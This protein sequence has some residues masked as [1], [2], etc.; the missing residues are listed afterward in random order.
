MTTAQE[1]VLDSPRALSCH[2]PVGL[3]PPDALMSRFS[4]LVHVIRGRNEPL[5]QNTTHSPPGARSEDQ[6]QLPQLNHPYQ[7][8]PGPSRVIFPWIRTRRA[9]H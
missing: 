5:S 6:N 8:A 4:H 1:L 7:M 3:N 2:F 9:H